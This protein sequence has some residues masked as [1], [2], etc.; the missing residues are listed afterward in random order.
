MARMPLPTPTL[1]TAR[2]RLRPFTGP[3]A[4][5]LFA[6]HALHAPLLLLAAWRARQGQYGGYPVGFRLF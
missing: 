2:L 1:R 6:L 3:D 4:D 5:A